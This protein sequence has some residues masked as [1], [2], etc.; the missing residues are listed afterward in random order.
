MSGGD[1]PQYY[2]AIDAEATGQ[3]YDTTV[4]SLGVYWAPAVPWDRRPGVL[5]PVKMRWSFQPQPHEHDDPGCMR[6]FWAKNLGALGT[7]HKEARP[8][9]EALAEF[10][11]W[12]EEGTR[13]RGAGNTRILSDCPEL[14]L[15]RVDW[16]GGPEA[17]GIFTYPIRHLGDPEVRHVM[18]NPREWLRAY[19]DRG[20]A[21]GPFDTWLRTWDP[22]GAIRHSHLP[23]DDAEHSYW[24]MIYC[25]M[26]RGALRVPSV[27]K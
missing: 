23:D 2:L 6:E 17:L 7:I 9:R 13:L 18:A 15:D 11:A 19:N 5:P 1:P 3:A 25:D 12:L 10:Y 4:N 27:K 21:G 24:M 22:R 8:V 14:D 26:R 20:R 16:L